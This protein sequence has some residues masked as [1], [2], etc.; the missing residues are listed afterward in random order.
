MMLCYHRYRGILKD[1]E[2]TEKQVM[3][4]LSMIEGMY[5]YIYTLKH[6]LHLE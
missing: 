5:V 6:P 3:S 2:E 4:T 1:M